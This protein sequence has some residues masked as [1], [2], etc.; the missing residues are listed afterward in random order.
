MPH[1]E[2]KSQT[3]LFDN[4]EP[5][6]TPARRDT[7]QV[8]MPGDLW[9]IGRHRL[10]CGDTGNSEDMKRLLNGK[11]ADLIHTDPPYNVNVDP[12]SKKED[13]ARV[14]RIES[15]ALSDE[16][17]IQRLYNW[18]HNMSIALAP[19]RSFYIWGGYS[20]CSRFPT[21]LQTANLHFAQ[22]IIWVKKTSVMSRR[23]F[24]SK[25]EWCFY[26]WKQREG[27]PH[28]FTH[29]PG[30]SDVWVFSAVPAKYS[31]HLTEK[32]VEIPKCAIECSSRPG[33]LILD[34]FAGSGSTLI[35]AEVL[36]R[37][38]YLMEIDSWYSSI[39]VDRCKR[40]GLKVE[41]IE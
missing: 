18:F 39:I 4:D 2:A 36:G 33:E 21:I 14:R 40:M 38:C 20:N 3:S 26:G 1:K 35:A 22:A 32:P 19:G 37:I 17:F 13:V 5:Q 10:L 16:K 28:F 41:K 27:H 6:Y 12:R 15:D 23:D 31:L 8:V 24:M 7:E 34:P 25:H 11:K 30:V 9:L 29:I